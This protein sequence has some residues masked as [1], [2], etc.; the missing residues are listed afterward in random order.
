[1][2]GYV[3]QSRGLLLL[4]LHQFFELTTDTE[5]IFSGDFRIKKATR[6]IVEHYSEKITVKALASAA[7]LNTAYFGSL[8]KKETGLTL[9]Q[10]LIKTRIQNAE[11]LLRSG[12]CNV[13]EAACNCGF[14][15]IAHFYKNFKALTGM[16]PSQFMP[17]R[18]G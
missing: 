4:L 16:A 9:N 2:P 3:L 14:S 8:F 10:Y 12:E 11:Y 18:G 6:Y 5:R 7:K 17:K 15:D 13:G 1:M